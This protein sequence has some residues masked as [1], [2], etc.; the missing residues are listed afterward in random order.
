MDSKNPFDF[1]TDTK[2][3]NKK[4]KK[5][6]DALD[7]NK[8]NPFDGKD[9]AILSKD[10]M[11]RQ[12]HKN[13]TISIYIG[14][15]SG[16]LSSVLWIVSYFVFHSLMPMYYFVVIFIAI[17]EYFRTEDVRQTA[18]ASIVFLFTKGIVDLIMLLI[19]FR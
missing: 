18:T 1:E 10:D 2:V 11:L 13:V 16:A 15:T 4:E 6:G 19:F 3:E 9:E 17:F 8:I 5:I 14:L 12:E 7:S